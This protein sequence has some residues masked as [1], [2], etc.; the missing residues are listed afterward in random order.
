MKFK[1]IILGIGILGAMTGCNDYLDVD[2]PSRYEN[3][4]VFGST[5]EMNTALNGVYAEI[6]SGNTFGGNLYRTL[7]L[8]SDVDFSANSNENAQTNAPQRF[9]CTSDASSASSLWNQLYETVEVANN[10][11]YNAE[12]SKINTP[13]NE[14]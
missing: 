12:N 4:Y 14:D 1:N 8:N 9:D 11:I 3:D 2:A 13:G 6:L 5:G 10:F 7:Q